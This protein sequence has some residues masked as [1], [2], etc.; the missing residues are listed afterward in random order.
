MVLLRVNDIS[1]SELSATCT[2]V[3]FTSTFQE[4][5][6][7]ES[8]ELPLSVEPSVESPES[9]LSK[10]FAIVGVANGESSNGVQCLEKA[11]GGL[12]KTDT[13]IGTTRKCPDCIM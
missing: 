8:S 9:D 10:S 1:S 11:S 12:S 2:N 5:V 6:E 7:S 4:L 13:G 3:F